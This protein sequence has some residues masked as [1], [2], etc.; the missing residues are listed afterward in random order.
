MI[1]N[2]GGWIKVVEAFVAVLLIGAV[3]LIII[4]QNEE[5]KDISSQA[6]NDEM[7][8]LRAIELNNDLRTGILEIDDNALPISSDNS[9]FPLEI[10]AKIEEK[11]PSYLACNMKICKIE[12]ECFI[13]NDASS[14]VYTNQITIFA[15]LEKYNPRKLV[16]SCVLA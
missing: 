1:K 16:I 11:K 9:G 15:N 14:D 3:L 5:N 13:N 8:M 12:Q 6:Y 2:K 10:K 7:M 4:N